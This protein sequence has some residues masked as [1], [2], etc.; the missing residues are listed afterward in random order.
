MRLVHEVAQAVWWLLK[1]AIVI[2]IAVW[3]FIKIPTWQ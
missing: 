1:A 2:G 3:M